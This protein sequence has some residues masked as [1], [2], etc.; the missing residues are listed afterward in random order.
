MAQF[1][2]QEYEG[3]NCDI[4]LIPWLNH[5]RYDYYFWLF[6]SLYI[7]LHDLT[8]LFLLQSVFGAHAL[9]VQSDRGGVH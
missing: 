7:A 5:R 2:V 9:L 4:S 8:S 6:R 3:R 1:F